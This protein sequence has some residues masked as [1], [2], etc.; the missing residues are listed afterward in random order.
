LCYHAANHEF[1]IGIF[2]RAWLRKTF[3]DG[4]WPSLPLIFFALDSPAQTGADD[5]AFTVQTLTNIAEPVFTSLADGK[6]KRACASLARRENHENISAWIV[7]KKP[8][9]KYQ[10]KSTS[11][12]EPL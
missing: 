6:L 1:S 8:S 2:S 12:V 3:G 9:G 10:S 7:G 5:R 11:Q 4:L